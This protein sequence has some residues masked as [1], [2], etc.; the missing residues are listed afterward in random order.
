MH[1]IRTLPHLFA[2]EISIYPNPTSANWTVDLPIT[3]EPAQLELFDVN[4]RKIWTQS[5]VY[6]KA[7]IPGSG[8]PAG[9][10]LLKIKIGT[11]EYLQ[12][13]VRR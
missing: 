12:K 6:F 13:L 1:L 8:I 3:A 9:I 5:K 7:E 10:Y 2:G 11:Q 4:G